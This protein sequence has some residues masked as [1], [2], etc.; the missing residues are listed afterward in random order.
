MPRR[1][2]TYLPQ[3]ASLHQVA[4]VGALL[5]LVGGFIWTYNFVVSWLEGPTVEDGDPWNLERE[6]M[7]TAEWE[8]FD[9]KLQTAIADGGDEGGDGELA[10]D[11]GREGD[12]T[13]GAAA[14]EDETATTSDD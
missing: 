5:L 13:A 2:A 12:A 6:R 7:R 3:F 8:W 1:Y 9:R 10:T 14:D 11:G 4:T